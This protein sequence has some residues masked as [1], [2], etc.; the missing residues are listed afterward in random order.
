MAYESRSIL[1]SP[2]RNDIHGL[3]LQLADKE[4]MLERSAY[5]FM[6][7]MSDFGGF[8]D[9]IAIFPAILMTLYNGKMYDAEKTSVFPIKRKTAKG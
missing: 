4:Y 8:N 2:V 7:L 5:S 1:E 3:K 9:G 6:T